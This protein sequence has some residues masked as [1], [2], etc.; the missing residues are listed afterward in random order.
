VP[1]AHRVVA[2]QLAAK[3]LCGCVPGTTLEKLAEWVEYHQERN[4]QARVSHEKATRRR[5]KEQGIR[6]TGMTRCQPST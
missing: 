6:L 3:R 1:Q 4:R 2:A 5:L